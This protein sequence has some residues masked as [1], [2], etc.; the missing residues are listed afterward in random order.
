MLSLP[1]DG[2]GDIRWDICGSGEGNCLITSSVEGLD[3][4]AGIGITGRTGLRGELRDCGEEKG[5]DDRVG[6]GE[7]GVGVNGDSGWAVGDNVG[8]GDA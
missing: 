7:R 2:C 1:V 3:G 6:V 4:T 5:G 8:T